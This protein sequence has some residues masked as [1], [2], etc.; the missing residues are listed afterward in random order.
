[1]GEQVDM[2]IDINSNILE[3][4]SETDSENETNDDLQNDTQFSI[5]FTNTNYAPKHN[6]IVISGAALVA[7]PNHTT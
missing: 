2:E 6:E 7:S 1:M 5:I 3:L 4:E